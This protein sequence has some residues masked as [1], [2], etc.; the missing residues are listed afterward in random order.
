MKKMNKKGFTLVELLTVIA[1]LAIILLIAAPTILNV[2]EKAKKNTFKSQVLMYVES[3][4]TQLALSSMG[5]ADMTITWN[6]IEENGTKKS[7]A[8]VNIADIPMDIDKKMTGTIIVTPQ[9][10]GRYEYKLVDVT[11]TKYTVSVDDATE[12]TDAD[13]QTYKAPAT[14]DTGA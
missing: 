2:L 4:K 8:E 11:D 10:N 7:V 3:L 1:I 5:T 13:I 12:M 6:E 14:P 9:G